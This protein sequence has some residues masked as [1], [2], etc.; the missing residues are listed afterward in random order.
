MPDEFQKL[1][2]RDLGAELDTKIQEHR[3]DGIE[4][5]QIF[6][7]DILARPRQYREFEV[8]EPATSVGTGDG[9]YFLHITKDLDDLSIVEVHALV[10]TAGTTGTTDV[11]IHNVTDSVDVLSTK[12]TIDSG[13]TGSDTAATPAVINVANQGVSENDVLRIDVDAVQTGTAPKGLY[14]TIEF[15]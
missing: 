6:Y 13:E 15:E 3:H 7:P 9:Q 1:K 11:Q 12:L 5:Q 8:V 10:G 2:P 4:A 14:I